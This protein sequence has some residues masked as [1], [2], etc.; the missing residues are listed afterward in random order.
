MAG[1]QQLTLLGALF[2]ADKGKNVKKFFQILGGIFLLLILIIAVMVGIVAY[3]GNRLDA[4]SKTY[5]EANVKPVVATWS[6]DELL[7]RAS[8]QLREILGKDPDQVDRLFAKLAKLGPLKSL[9]EPKGQSLVSVNTGSGKVVSAS[10]TETGEFEN[11]HADFN[12]RLVQ[13]E[14]QWR[15]FGFYVNS[16]I[17]LQ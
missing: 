14:G 17:M 9:S 4:S 13:I 15:F 6:K 11:G 3:Q 8:P 12:I 5:V 2:C 1:L 16:P 7:K 10:Y